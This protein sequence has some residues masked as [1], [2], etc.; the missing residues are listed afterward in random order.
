MNKLRDVKSV[1]IFPKAKIKS[2]R[3]ALLA[4]YDARRRELPW[5]IRPEARASGI[6]PDPYAIWLSEIMLQQTTVAHGTPY[7]YAFLEKFP[8]VMNLA[9]AERDFVLTMWAGLGYY[10]RARNLHRCAQ[11]IRDEFGGAFPQSEA[12]LLKLPGIGPYTAATM[13]AIC[14]DEVTNIVDGNVERVISRIFAVETPLPKGRKDIWTCAKSL[15]VPEGIKVTR[16]GDYGQALMDLGGRICTPKSP[17][18]GECPWQADCSAFKSGNPETYPRKLKKAQ[19]AVRHGAGFVLYNK[20]RVLL[21]RR[22]DKGLLGGMLGLPVTPWGDKPT[23]EV[24]QSAAPIARNWQLCD[25][26][27]KH[28]FTH[29]ELR[30]SVYKAEVGEHDAA[31][32]EAQG[33]IWGQCSALKT[34]ALPTLM[35]K[36]YKASLDT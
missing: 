25:N 12:E 28:V 5:R 26:G 29:F 22:P 36:V 30:L 13:A 24:V 6:T 18:C 33:Y 32:L 8:T 16:P 19:L 23:S 35:T 27:V 14:F 21:E 10:A 2:L 4:H 3:R 31:K 7:W 20:G 34:Y 17:K 15:A 11:M 9:N 1:H